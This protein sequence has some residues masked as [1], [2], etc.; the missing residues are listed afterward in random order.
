MAHW[1]VGVVDAPIQTF[2]DPAARPPIQWLPDPGPRRFLADPFGFERDGERVLLVEDFDY[3][4]VRGC[5]AALHEGRSPR[6]TLRSPYHMSYPFVLWDEGAPW[7]I[8]ETSAAGEVALYA[9]EDDRLVFDSL[10][11]REFPGVDSTVFKYQDR[12]WM[13]NGR[14]GPRASTDLYAWSARALRGPWVPHAHN[15]VKRDPRGS[16]PAGTPFWADG[17]LYR[18]AQD[19]AGGYGSAVAIYRIDRLDTAG[20]V[21]AIVSRVR[22]DPSGPYPDGLHTLSAVG[23]RTLVDGNRWVTLAED[24][25]LVARARVGIAR[26]WLRL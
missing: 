4:S 19:G 15:P 14:A 8:P 13:L 17:A 18:P 24:P 10:L 23:D 1:N 25:W 16:R 2:L 21:E 5:I 22:P 20:L 9:V 12:W 26:R 11:L 3:S 6:S 7:C